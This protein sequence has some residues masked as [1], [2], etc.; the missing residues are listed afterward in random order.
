V[1]VLTV[2]GLLGTLA[3][4]GALAGCGT[5]GTGIDSTS[6]ACTVLADEQYFQGYGAS[7][8]QAFQSAMDNCKL[9]S[10]QSSDCMGDP[11]KCM[12]PK[13]GS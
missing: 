12:P 13:G 10:M 5:Q 2:S 6:W 3:L 1:R 4:V 11:Q 9:N 7:R 8:E